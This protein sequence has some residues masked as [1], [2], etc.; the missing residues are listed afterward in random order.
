M[1]NI[2]TLFTLF[3]LS[4]I[5]TEL[6]A[7]TNLEYSRVVLLQSQATSIVALGTVPTGKVWKIESYGGANVNGGVMATLNGIDAGILQAPIGNGGLKYNS[8]SLP[9]WLPA[10]TD[11]GF[12]TNPGN[13]LVWFSII[14]FTI[15]P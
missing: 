11:L 13:E 3:L 1:K 5:A 4:F 8:W 2:I 6:K 14:E 10:G 9:V 7:Q 12:N 15:V